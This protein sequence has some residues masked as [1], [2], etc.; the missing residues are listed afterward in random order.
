[1]EVEGIVYKLVFSKPGTP[2]YV[3]STIQTLCRRRSVHVDE[4]TYKNSKISKAIREHGYF[5]LEILEPKTKYRNI[6]AL[7][8][9]EREFM[10]LLK[11]ELN[12]HRSYRSEEEAKIYKKINAQKQVICERCNKRISKNHITRHKRTL[13]CINFTT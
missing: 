6:Q 7:H 13:T 3:G 4:A 9:K 12:T 1:M 11:P 8:I 10:E 5:T 2:F